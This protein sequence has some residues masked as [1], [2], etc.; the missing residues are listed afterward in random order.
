MVVQACEPAEYLNATVDPLG[1]GWH[2][3]DPAGERP[4]CRPQRYVNLEAERVVFDGLHR[5]DALEAAVRRAWRRPRA[6]AWTCAP[7][8]PSEA[9]VRRHSEL[10][11]WMP[12]LM[13][14]TQHN[15]HSTLGPLRSLEGKV[16]AAEMWSVPPVWK[17]DSRSSE[18]ERDSPA[19]FT[20]RSCCDGVKTH[21][22][23]R[24]R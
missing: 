8:T 1:P 4:P 24:L 7:R 2:D 15:L 22:V 3:L 23:S 6:T 17:V 13:F 16:L 11:I 14:W 12:V 18:W 19:C 20:H 10:C 21:A 9:L 5:M